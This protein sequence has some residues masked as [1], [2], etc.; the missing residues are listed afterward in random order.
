MGMMTVDVTPEPMDVPVDYEAGVR[1]GSY[2]ELAAD[3]FPKAV[4]ADKSKAKVVNFYGF[5]L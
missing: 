2:V 1:V 3:G 4:Y 5:G